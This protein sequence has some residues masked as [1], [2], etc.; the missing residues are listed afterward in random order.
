MAQRAVQIA[1]VRQHPV[2]YKLSCAHLVI[3]ESVN[4]DL[5]HNQSILFILHL[6]ELDHELHDG[7]LMGSEGL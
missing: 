6:H 2:Q 3:T 1:P 4:E 7:A 5:D